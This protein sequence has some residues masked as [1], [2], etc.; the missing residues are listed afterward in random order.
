MIPMT[1]PPT[2]RFEKEGHR[3]HLGERELISVTTVLAEAGL[4]DDRFYTEE[5]AQRG[6][7]VHLALE[8]LDQG[9]LS[10]E[11]IEPAYRP[12]ILAYQRFCELTW[13]VWSHLEHRLYDDVLGYAGTLDRAGVL[14][15]NGQKFVIDIKTG[16]VPRWA[17]LQTAAYRRC[18][19]EP[20]TWKRAAL[21]LKAD[22]TF[23]LC[24]CTERSDE[25]TFLSAL[26]L[27]LWKRSH[28]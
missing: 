25:R 27:A 3:Y 23:S 6:T 4:V 5:A 11:A 9:K 20:H 18:L 19:P 16:S 14:T 8:L 10:D 13:P 15:S 12:Y 21:Q 28:R 17:G 22:G 7:Y 26:T 24:E 2:L 1:L